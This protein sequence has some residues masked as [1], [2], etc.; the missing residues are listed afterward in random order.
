M[1]SK[2]SHIKLA[3]LFLFIGG[4]LLHGQSVDSLIT[5]ELVAFDRN[6]LG[7]AQLETENEV[8][9]VMFDDF[10]YSVSFSSYNIHDL[11][12]V[13]KF[14]WRRNADNYPNLEIHVVEYFNNRIFVLYSSTD[15]DTKE[16][17]VSLSSIFLDG[18][19]DQDYE[20]SRTPPKQRFLP[21]E[22]YIYKSKSTA[23]M[24]V[25]LSKESFKNI[26]AEVEIHLINRDLELESSHKITLPGLEKIASPSQF[27][28]SD[29]GL[30]YFLSGQDKMKAEVDGKLGLEKK[31]YQLYMYNHQIE[32]LKQFDVSIADKFISDVKM[33]LHKNGDLFVLGFYNNTHVKGAEGV[34]LMV[35]DGKSP[36][37]K[38]SGK[39]KLSTEIKKDF[40][41]GKRLI[42]NPVIDDLYLDHFHI[43]E[44]GNIVFIGEVFYVD[45]RLVNQAN[46]SN[47]TTSVYYNFNEILCVELDSRL[48]YV[49]HLTIPKHQK[50]VNLYNM[51]YSY[52]VLNFESENPL[53]V[54]NYAKN[55]HGQNVTEISGISKTYLYIQPIFSE[56]FSK[57]ELPHK[58]KVKVAPGIN[59]EF[60]N[61]FL[62]LQNKRKYLVSEV[63][64]K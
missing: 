48:N 18:K 30:V 10:D 53:I 22:Y 9:H 61:D 50:S 14:I 56:D 42:K 64:F 52:S 11:S 26:E 43:K 51:Y 39:K 36:K 46:L 23:Y 4:Q 49:Q 40:I 7:I 20:I 37:V 34:F 47:L 25:S 45:K 17:V 13:K 55:K 19:W 31:V 41:S 32:R 59:K 8:I 3:F 63:V 16:K 38:A 62:V 33:K 60:K 29:L 54:Y 12:Q 58:S 2:T 28:I 5:S 35:I 27:Q 24:G 57:L 15:A 6:E 44:N 21:V 1:E